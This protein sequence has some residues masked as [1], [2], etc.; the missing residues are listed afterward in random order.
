MTFML[1]CGDICINPSRIL[2]KERDFPLRGAAPDGAAGGCYFPN[3]SAGVTS[4]PQ[5]HIQGIWPA[6]ATEIRQGNLA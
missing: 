6:N 1:L 3:K 5:N 4:L 2:F